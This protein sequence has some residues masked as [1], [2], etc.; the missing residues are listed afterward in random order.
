VVTKAISDGATQAEVQALHGED[1]VEE[2][3]RMLG[4][5]GAAARRHAAEMLRQT[6]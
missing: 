3:A 2:L 5:S 6:R 1:R 4:G